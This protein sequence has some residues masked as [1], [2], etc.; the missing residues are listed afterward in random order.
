MSLRRLY[1][2]LRPE[3]DNFLFAAVRGRR[4][5]FERDL[6]V[7]PAWPRS[8]G[9][10]RSAF[11]IGERDALQLIGQL[12][13]STWPSAKAQS[14]SAGL[15]D[16]L[17]AREKTARSTLKSAKVPRSYLHHLGRFVQMLPAKVFRPI[18]CLL[19]AAAIVSMIAHGG[20]PFGG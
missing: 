5:P 16:L 14:I 15:I 12:P 4:H 17:P 6:G 1:Q 13:G 7:D 20:F 9:R 11:V 8:L 10:G 3:L 18:W 19:G 2:P